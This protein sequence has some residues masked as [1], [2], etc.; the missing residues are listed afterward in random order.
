MKIVFISG[1]QFGYEILQHILEN[2]WEISAVFSYLPEKQKVYSDY[3]N[4]EELRKKYQF[5]HKQVD[6][7]N[8]V[9]NIEIIKSIK[10]DLIFVMGWSQLLKDEIIKIPRL[11]VIGSHP[12]EL[13][14]YRGRA[15][16]P[17]SIL[18]GLKKSALTFFFIEKGVDNGDILEQRFFEITDKDDAST[19][20]KKIISLGKSMILDNLL[21]FQKKKICRIKQ[22]SEEFIEYWPKRNPEDGE[23]NWSKSAKDIH[24]LIRATT[25]PY[26]GAFTTF[27]GKIMKIWKGDFESG[28]N[29]TPGKIISVDNRGVKVHTQK[30][31]LVL[32]KISINGNDF[33]ADKVI[34]L[35]DIGTILGEK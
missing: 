29:G 23:I 35:K 34:T 21:L 1:V 15:P 20:Y 14:K 17:W 19:L 25:H 24:Q 32:K 30:G 33:L 12:T 16:I 3:S 7:I 10:P 31:I 9:E 28:G 2:N 6:N 8:N 18:K 11:G 26:P 13:P 27:N 22:K 5:I 4:F